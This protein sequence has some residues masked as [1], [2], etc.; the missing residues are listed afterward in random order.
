ML[1][2]GTMS[3]VTVLWV[4]IGYSLAFAPSINTGVIGDTSLA[5]LNYGDTP[6]D[7]TTLPESSF[8]MFQL[9][10]AGEELEQW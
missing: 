1:S 5:L 4:L 9:M 6:R 8:M 7:G 3:C 10:F 2:F